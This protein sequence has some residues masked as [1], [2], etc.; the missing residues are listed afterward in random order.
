MK[1]VKIYKGDS[2]YTVDTEESLEFHQLQGWSLEPPAPA[3]AP[4]IVLTPDEMD[5]LRAEIADLRAQLAAI[6]PEMIKGQ[7]V[8]LAKLTTEVNK[9]TATLGINPKA[10]KK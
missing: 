8:L 5:D 1:P 9:I 10:G 7:G 3:P 2:E 6:N 4:S